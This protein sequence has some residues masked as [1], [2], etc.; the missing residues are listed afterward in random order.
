MFTFYEEKNDTYNMLNST[1]E[2]INKNPNDF[3]LECFPESF[4]V[5]GNQQFLANG[6]TIMDN[7]GNWIELYLNTTKE[8]DSFT[9]YAEPVVKEDN[10][11][12]FVHLLGYNNYRTRR[13]PAPIHPLRPILITFVVYIRYY[14]YWPPFY[15]VTFTLGLYYG[16]P[17]YFR[18]LQETN[19]T[20]VQNT[21]SVCTYDGKI[22]LETGTALYN[23]SAEAEEI[24]NTT[25][26]YNNFEFFTEEGEPVILEEGEIN[27]SRDAIESGKNLTE[28]TSTYTDIVSIT[29][30][31]F[32]LNPDDENSF[33]VKGYLEG[34]R[35]NEV[36]NR[37]NIIMTFYEEIG[38]DTKIG[39]NTTCDIVNSD[40]NDFL[41][42]CSPE[43]NITGSQFL[44]NGTESTDGRIGIYLNTSDTDEATKNFKFIKYN[45]R[46]G[47]FKWRKNSRGLSGGAI[48]GIVI[49]CACVLI[50]ITILAMFLRKS[51]RTQENQSTIVG[52]K[53]IDN[54]NE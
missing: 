27:Y 25:Q 15:K 11:H 18:R 21:T 17:Y 4:H 26:S 7:N 23:C 14:N 30:A 41:I 12:A 50:L 1:C 8:S 45:N 34:S 28:Q 20:N 32:V 33:F 22:D 49:A 44:A 38:D 42:K 47:N 35:K 51:K 2:V 39:H 3:Q 53:S 19:D 6:T 40:P 36:A 46:Y 43:F 31:K 54:Y 5:N 37:N 48:A 29:D 9:Y 16:R 13:N 10:R 24:P 52:L